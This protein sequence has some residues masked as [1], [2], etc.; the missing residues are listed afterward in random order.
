M[1]EALR[2]EFEQY[3]SEPCGEITAL[4]CAGNVVSLAAKDKAGEEMRKDLL[5]RLNAGEHIELVIDAVTFAQGPS[6]T[7]RNNI[8][9]APAALSGFAKS[10][11]GTPVLQDHRLSTSSMIGYCEASKVEGGAGG[12]KMLAEKLRVVHP[13][14]VRAVLDGRMREFSIGWTTPIADIQC[15]ACNAPI[16]ECMHWPGDKVETKKGEVIARFRYMSADAV[17]RSWVAFPAV[18]KATET[19]SWEQLSAARES[20]RVQ[21]QATITKETNM[22][23]I[24]KALGMAA[25]ADEAACAKRIREIK[26]ELDAKSAAL[27]DA[28]A[29][30]KDAQEALAAME[31]LKDE[32]AARKAK[33]LDQE[34]D[35]SIAALVAEGRIRPGG[36]Q[37]KLIRKHFDDGKLGA[38][39]AVIESCKAGEKLVPVGGRQSD[40]AADAAVPV[41]GLIAIPK[42]PDGK[43]DF[44]ALCAALPEHVTLMAAAAIKRDPEQFVRSTKARLAAYI[45]ISELG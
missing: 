22:D 14:G 28:G 21:R 44:K 3:V 41:G 10:A 25:G 13:D 42:G 4:D 29:N 45:D 23:E 26:A 9:F 8:E 16:T 7:N 37:E 38:A 35:S 31:S 33:E 40:P 39:R 17:E 30:L 5:Q 2:E 6:I 32:L 15:T 20:M 12:E 18:R 19:R 1:S 27:E 34:C 24:A 36:A 11:K 43:I